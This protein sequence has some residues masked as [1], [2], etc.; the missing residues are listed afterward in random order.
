MGKRITN[1]KTQKRNRDRVSVYLDGDF[2]FGLA[3]IEAARLHVGQVLSEEEIAE[4]K[5]LDAVQRAAERAMNLLSYRPRSCEEVRRRLRKKDYTED[6][7]EE[8]IERLERAG[9]LDD[10]AFARYWIE[11]RFRFNPRGK[12]FLRQELRQKGVRDRV[13]EEALDG[14]DEQTAAE[15]AAAAAVRRLRRLD[16]PT[17][18]RKL[19]GYLRRRGFFYGTIRPIVEELVAERT[20]EEFWEEN[21]E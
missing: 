17:F 13:I 3:L 11:N 9:L 14:Y 21:E 19:I 18:R 1:L 16:E 7:I 8:A 20:S 4:L 5:D 10:R 12:A 6:T 15:E 2:A